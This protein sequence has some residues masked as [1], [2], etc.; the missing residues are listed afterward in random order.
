MAAGVVVEE[1][2]RLERLLR[3][4]L[5]LGVVAATPALQLL[6]FEIHTLAMVAFGGFIL[7]RFYRLAWHGDRP[8][9]SPSGGRDLEKTEAS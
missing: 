1:S 4:L 3:A 9:D 6:G 7:F 2:K 8:A 5:D